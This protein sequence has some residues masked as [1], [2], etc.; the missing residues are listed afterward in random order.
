MRAS[1][2]HAH[3]DDLADADGEHK[4]LVAVPAMGGP[5]GSDGGTLGYALPPYRALR[6]LPSPPLSL[7][8]ASVAV[9][10][11]ATRRAS[12]G[13]VAPPRPVA[14]TPRPPSPPKKP[15]PSVPKSAPHQVPRPKRPGPS[16]QARA[17]PP[18]S[19]CAPPGGVKLLPVRQRARV[20]HSHALALLGEGGAVAFARGGR[21]VRAGAT[22]VGRGGGWAR[23]Q[24]RRR[25]GGRSWPLWGTGCCPQL[26]EA[27]ALIGCIHRGQRRG[28]RLPRRPL[29]MRVLCCARAHARVRRTSLQDLLLQPQGLGLG[30][31]GRFCR[32]SGR[33]RREEGCY[34]SENNQ[35]EDHQDCRLVA[36]AP[37][38]LGPVASSGRCHICVVLVLIQRVGASEG[39]S[40]PAR[41]T[42]FFEAPHRAIGGRA[43]AHG[44]LDSGH[45]RP[46]LRNRPSR[47]APT[48]EPPYPAR[49]PFLHRCVLSPSARGAS[50]AML[51]A[52]RAHEPAAFPP[53]KG[54]GA[55]LSAYVQAA[56]A[57]AWRGGCGA[58]VWPD[59]RNGGGCKRA[60]AAG[61][62]EWRR[63]RNSRSGK[64]QRNAYK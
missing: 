42:R 45:S 5:G 43:G 39:L 50:P 62:R 49:V 9:Q 58:W 1:R 32:R 22:A 47:H 61:N 37:R 46:R 33:L 38:T 12:L 8:R 29:R 44:P 18:S 15:P 56:G 36:P 21:G 51:G 35:H 64:A 48:A 41:R 59:C 40:C 16:A 52:N 7:P 60:V 4:G 10:R 28:S 53:K 54:S 23:R 34:A 30:L 17:P 25:G 27:A 2:T 24:V 3:L 31:L 11:A 55:V 14:P 26:P 13:K 57:P 20:V 19:Q 6:A 63:A